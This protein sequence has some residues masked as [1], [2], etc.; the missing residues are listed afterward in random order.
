MKTENIRK[1]FE[2]VH[3]VAPDADYLDG[4]YHWSSHPDSVH[5]PKPKRLNLL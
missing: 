5:N 2:S 1:H 4:Q 3:G